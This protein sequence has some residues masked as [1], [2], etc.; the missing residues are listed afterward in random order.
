MNWNRRNDPVRRS[1]AV[2]AKLCLLGL[3]AIGFYAM[4]LNH[5]LRSRTVTATGS[6]FACGLILAL[7]TYAHPRG[8]IAACTVSIQYLALLIFPAWLFG[9]GMENLRG[10]IFV[11]WCVVA[12]IFSLLIIFSAL[13]MCLMAMGRHHIRIGPLFHLTLIT[14]G[15]NDQKS[16]DTQ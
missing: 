8:L 13:A 9:Y 3:G 16:I 10:W 1:S 2:A 12:G 14:Q 7:L 11:L 6:I 4:M 5:P 15:D